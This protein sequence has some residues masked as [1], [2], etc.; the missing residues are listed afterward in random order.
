MNCTAS[1]YMD[2]I[3]KDEFLDMINTSNWM[4]DVW[5]NGVMYRHARSYAAMAFHDEVHQKFYKAK[6]NPQPL[7]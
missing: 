2:E 1:T 3:S 4:R 7:S 5:A 6:P